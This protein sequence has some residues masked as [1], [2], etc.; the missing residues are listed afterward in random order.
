MLLKPRSSSQEGMKVHNPLLSPLRLLLALSC[1]AILLTLSCNSGSSSGKGDTG[2]VSFALKLPGQSGTPTKATDF[3]CW[4]TGITSIQAE[5]YDENNNLIA[6][7]GPWDCTQGSGVISGV[8]AGPFRTV[9]VSCLNVSGN[10]N[11]RGMAGEVE[12]TENA[13][14]DLGIIDLNPVV[15]NTPPVLSTLSPF[16][17]GYFVGDTIH[18][19]LTTSYASDIV[20]NDALTMD[21]GNLPTDALIYE[22]YS[23]FEWTPAAGE[24]KVLFRVTDNGTPP[25]TDYQWVTIRVTSMAMALNHT[26]VLSL[27]TDESLKVHPGDEVSIG[28]VGTDADGGDTL[29]YSIESV[30]GKTNVPGTA[31]IDGSD[32][33]RWD[34]T[35]AAPGNY[36]V[37]LQ[38][39]DTIGAYDYK[40]VT[41]S[42][43]NVNRP[44][45]LTPIG[46]RAVYY[47][48]TL[49]FPVTGTDPDGDTLSYSLESAGAQYTY[50]AGANIESGVFSWTGTTPGTYHVRIKV[51]D[52]GSPR[53]SDFEDIVI[54]SLPLVQ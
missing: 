36:Y 53:E 52:N 37:R 26:P 22:S 35:D 51:R 38:A 28:L 32:V 4:D 18:F 17:T 49:T 8:K 19:S 21:I 24:Y 2:T 50:P 34:T 10:V 3:D 30:P 25:L 11:Y 46:S 16:F 14:T 1:A 54:T 42:V 31:Y 12:V 47:G 29:S 41:I 33:F 23:E 20:D 5:V 45:V 39:T 40:D 9:I 7:G 44:P 48:F 13:T 15:D 27:S 6:Q 43:G